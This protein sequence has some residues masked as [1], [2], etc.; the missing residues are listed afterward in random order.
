M[1]AR[2]L[3]VE[4]D[5][6]TRESVQDAWAGSTPEPVHLLTLAVVALVAGVAATKLFRWE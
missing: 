5:P 4:D 1:A 3:V 6:D 2:I